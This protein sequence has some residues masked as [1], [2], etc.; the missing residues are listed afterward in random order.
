M[1]MFEKHVALIMKQ[2]GR[3]EVDAKFIAW[4]E[5]AKGYWVRWEKDEPQE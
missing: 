3:G 2:D 5:G 4:C 1:E